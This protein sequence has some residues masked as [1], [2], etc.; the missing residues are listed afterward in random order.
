M[1]STLRDEAEEEQDPSSS[2]SFSS[3]SFFSS[4]ADP[5]S[6][7]DTINASLTFADRP[8]RFHL[9]VARSQRFMR[10]PPVCVASWNVK[11]HNWRCIRRA[12]A[13]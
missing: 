11:V 2:S 13:A 3:S 5:F 9:S 10:R 12:S 7:G 8:P 1:P 6:A 4:R